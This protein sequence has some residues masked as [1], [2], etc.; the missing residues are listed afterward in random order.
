MKSRKWFVHPILIFT[1]SIL[2][3]GASLFLYIYW[4]IEASVGLRAAVE[5]FNLDRGQVLGVETW[6][7]IMV[8]SVLVGVIL[9]GIFGIFVYGQ[10]TL[11]LYR[12]QNNFISNFTHELKTPVTSLK[13]FLQ[14]MSK[15]DLS[16]ENQLKYIRFMITDV[17]RLSNNI[18]RILNLAKLE[19]KSY[20]HEF[21]RAE[22]LETMAAFIRNNEHIFQEG[23]IVIHPPPEKL[24]KIR[25]DIPLFEM[26]LMNLLINAIKYN[27]SDMPQ[28]DIRFALNGHKE[29]LVRFEDNGI[30]M[31]KKEIRKVF[32]KF[33]QV[34]RAND[35]TAKGSGLGLHLVQTIAQLHKWK[36]AAGSE[37]R[38]K[39]SVFSLTMPV[40]GK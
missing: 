29:L 6:M 7:V 13:L 30:G 36:V 24:P 18:N 17:N 2:A 39:G 15:H 35:M 27:T 25:I 31:D 37:G 28:I 10:K 12:L 3:L 38:G 22:L 23:R 40:K 11:Q 21:L 33:Y 4:Y 1:L 26:L 8:L 20:Q 9:M 32:R 14:T 19:S 34:G 16:R 5:K